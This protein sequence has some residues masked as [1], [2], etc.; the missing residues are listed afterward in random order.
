MFLRRDKD[1]LKSAEAAGR[2]LWV[3]VKKKR[4]A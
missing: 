1:Q 2:P 3:Q 4:K